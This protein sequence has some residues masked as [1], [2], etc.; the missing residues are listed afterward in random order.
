MNI[1]EV[2]VSYTTNNTEKLRV[3]NS[4]TSYN[5][6]LACWNKNTLELQEEFKVLLLN[7]NN[8][9]LGI[10]PLSKGG[11]A[12]SIVDVKLLFSV[13]LKCN[14]HGIILAHNHPSGNLTPSEADKRLTKKIVEASRI[15]DVAIL[16]HIILSK[17]D[18]Y[19]F[20][21]NNIL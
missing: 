4:K 10:Y 12:S 6:L 9:V 18:Y 1:A 2:K 5:V 14:T 8:Q 21:D 20:S 13:A 3:T 11:T 19:S 17:N 7:R 16:D 15:L